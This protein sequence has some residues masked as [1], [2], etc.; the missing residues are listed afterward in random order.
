ML[1]DVDELP[2]NGR[3]MRNAVQQR[4][5]ERRPRGLRALV[6]AAIAIALL[7]DCL[8]LRAAVGRDG[9]AGVDLP[10]ELLP[11]RG[12]HSAGRRCSVR[13]IREA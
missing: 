9:L 7:C 3:V 13:F 11:C 5:S 6:V 10:A 12:G 4:P 1:R 2:Q 8:G